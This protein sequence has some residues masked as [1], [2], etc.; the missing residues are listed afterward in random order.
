MGL[1]EVGQNGL[2]ISL[3]TPHTIECES[4]LRIDELF[5]YIK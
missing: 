4:T 1:I 3:N 2:K 5:P